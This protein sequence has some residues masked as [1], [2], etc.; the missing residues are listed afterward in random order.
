MELI[1][2][3]HKQKLKLSQGFTLLEV[4]IAIVILGIL[5]AVVSPSI[6]GTLNRAKLKDAT[7]DLESALR[8]AQGIAIK[9]SQTCTVTIN[10]TSTVTTGSNQYY[11]VTA[12]SIRDDRGTTSTTDDI[13]RNCILETRYI[14]RRRGGADILQLKTSGPGTISYDFNGEM[15][16][17]SNQTIVLYDEKTNQSKCIV[18]S[19]PL[20]LIRSGEYNNTTQMTSAGQTNNSYITGGN[21]INIENLRYDNNNY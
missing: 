14:L 10:N 12:T 13:F 1:A 16:T 9:Y 7:E 17:A 5:T 15:A 2:V 3:L 20:A 6:M 4:I 11:T 8:L 21:C 18:L 19:S